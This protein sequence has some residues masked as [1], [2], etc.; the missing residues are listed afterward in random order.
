MSF[1]Q[2]DWGKRGIINNIIILTTWGEYIIYDIIPKKYQKYP[3]TI[4]LKHAN[5][6]A[7][8]NKSPYGNL[9]NIMP[10][11]DY[12]ITMHVHKMTLADISHEQN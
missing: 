12:I 4:I 7:K 3:S 9:F 10:H 11:E 6:L 5:N 2:N 1:T 8:V